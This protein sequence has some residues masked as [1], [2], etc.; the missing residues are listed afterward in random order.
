M[1][2]ITVLRLQIERR[3]MLMRSDVLEVVGF[4]SIDLIR[5][6]MFCD[7]VVSYLSLQGIATTV[8]HLPVL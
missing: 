4:S 6:S 5:C 2:S 7:L 8:L 1:K 3:A